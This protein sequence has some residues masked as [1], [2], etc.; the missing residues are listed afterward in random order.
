MRLA[1]NGERWETPR[2]VRQFG[3]KTQRT[4]RLGKPVVFIYMAPHSLPKSST[5]L[6]FSRGR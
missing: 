5:S 2:S 3:R 4:E 6:L 1:A